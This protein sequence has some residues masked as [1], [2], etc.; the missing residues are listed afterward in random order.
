MPITPG[1]TTVWMNDGSSPPQT[2]VGPTIATWLPTQTWFPVHYPPPPPPQPPCPRLQPCGAEQTGQLDI[3][4]VPITPPQLIWP[5]YPTDY[6]P[7]L[8]QAGTVDY[9]PRFSLDY[10]VLTPYPAQ[11]PPTTTL[12]ILLLV[13]YAPMLCHMLPTPVTPACLPSCPQP[14]PHLLLLPPLPYPLTY[15]HDCHET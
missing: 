14:P 3:G 6:H 10:T 12:P 7:G 8:E 15:H 11:T 4:T 1:R 2:V 9:H 5:D 13:L